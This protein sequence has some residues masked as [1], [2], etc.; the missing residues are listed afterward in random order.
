VLQKKPGVSN[1]VTLAYISSKK[2][3]YI[4]FYFWGYENSEGLAIIQDFAAHWAI[5][6]KEMANVWSFDLES[7]SSYLEL[8][9]F[10]YDSDIESNG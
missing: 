9:M 8:R 6:N 10:S 7:E 1:F 2:M 4:Y 5:K 3:I